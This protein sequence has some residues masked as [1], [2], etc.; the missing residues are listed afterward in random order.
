MA[1]KIHKKDAPLDQDPPSEAILEADGNAAVTSDEANA[2]HTEADASTDDGLME[3]K[4]KQATSAYAKTAEN[5]TIN[6][7]S[8]PSDP[9]GG[10]PDAPSAESPAQRADD[11]AATP[12]SAE[13][14][15]T[16]AQRTAAE[17]ENYRKRIKREQAV[18]RRDILGAFLKEFLPAFDDLDRAMA[19]GEKTTDYDAIHNGV[20]LVRTNLWKT[21][22][23]VGVKE[24]EAKGLKFNPAYHEAMT[25]IPAPD[26]EPNTVMDVYQTGYMI[27]DFVLRPA[28]VVVS[29]PA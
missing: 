19:E 21:L 15:K 2:P 22:E 12:G 5:A 23:R 11:S 17:F 8:E 3:A 26:T 7:E 18:W 27:E 29:A 24:I 10:K 14:Y 28:K 16:V 6:D 9:A 20:A 25:A 1:K 13:Y 4:R